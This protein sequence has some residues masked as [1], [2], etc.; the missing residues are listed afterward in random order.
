MTK[1]H[2]IPAQDG[3]APHRSQHTIPGNLQGL[4]GPILG[5]RRGRHF[6]SSLSWRQMFPQVTGTIYTRIRAAPCLHWAR[7]QNVWKLPLPNKLPKGLLG[8]QKF[9]NH[10]FQVSSFDFQFSFYTF[11]AYAQGIVTFLGEITV[12]QMLQGLTLWSHQE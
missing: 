2:A 10:W 12:I 3:Q 7:I 11:P 4:T 9:E 8:T 1:C 5:Y 6:L